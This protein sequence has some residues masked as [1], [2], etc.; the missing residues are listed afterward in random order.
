MRSIHKGI[1]FGIVSAILMMS[2]SIAAPIVASSAD[3]NIVDEERVLY[4]LI[5]R[6]EVASDASDFEKQ[7]AVDAFIARSKLPNK[8]SLRE[9]RNEAKRLQQSK[10]ASKQLKV[11]GAATTAL[12]NKTVKVMAVLID[13]PDLPHDDNGLSSSDTEMFY[14]SYPAEHYQNLLFSTNGYAGPSGQTLMT[15]YQYYQAESGQ[16]LFFTGTVQGW[17]RAANNAAYYGGNSGG[18]ADDVNAA[19]L[20][21]EAVAAAAAQM[22]EVELAS[23]DI[24]D[25]YDFNQNGI[26]DEPD[27]EIDHVMIFHSSIGEEVGGGMLGGDAIWSHRASI[28]PFD[29]PGTDMMLST[30]TIQP[31]DAALGVCVHEFGHD[32]G[33]K[34]EY[35]I[36]GGGQ[37]SPVGNWSVMASGSWA[38]AIRGTEPVGFSPYARAYLQ[39]RYQ[40]NW[41]SEQK[42]LLSSLDGS[43]LEVALVEAVNHEGV[44]QISLDIPPEELDFT[45]PY[46]G[47]Y[48]FYSDQGDLL[49]HAMSLD[50][51]LPVATSLVL[52][53]QAHWNI[54]LDY[55]Y[56]QVM[57]DGVALAGNYTKA[58]ND[59]NSAK[60][61][62]TGSSSELPA[63]QGDNSWVELEYDLSAY[64]GRNVRLSIRYTTDAYVG[65]Y[66]IVIDDISIMQAG[67]PWLFIGAETTG[68]AAFA[69]F[70]R[71]SDKRPGKD[72]RYLV[73]LRSHKGVDQGLSDERYDPGVV[74]WLENN[75]YSTNEVSDHA[76][77]SLIGVVDADQNLIGYLDSEFQMRDAAFS[78]FNQSAYTRNGS[79]DRHLSGHKL[80]A[81]TNDYSAPLQPE[82]GMQL[83]ELGLSMEVMAQ[84]EDSS[85]AT[86]QF[87]YTGSAV[88]STELTAVIEYVQQGAQVSF[89]AN[90]NGGDGNY[91]YAW[92]FGVDDAVSA[93]TKPSYTYSEEGS[94]LVT[95]TITDGNGV[96]FTNSSTVTISAALD[97]SF[98]STVNGLVVTFVNLSTGGNGELSY[99]WEFGDG[100]IS[101]QVSPSHSYGSTGDYSVVLTVTDSDGQQQSETN[102]VSVKSTATTDTT[103]TQK[104]GSGG[105]LGMLSLL[106][107]LFFASFRRT[108]SVCV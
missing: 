42:L 17:Y 39:E 59:T 108:K 49:S 1:L 80:F 22:N 34:D 20:V 35:D 13:F 8:I 104:S 78:L 71:V 92:D 14:S 27:G 5:K 83:P 32:L 62:I 93:L 65:D 72:R 10:Q 11:S 68:E 25:P 73:Q 52:T 107:L 75:N 23:Y 54:E 106:C 95:L 29:I 99:L 50:V 3:A 70:L 74:L 21:K 77:Y 56:A 61:I 87:T 41:V 6:G 58:S 60:N 101:S 55:D 97:A 86:V 37:G 69:G 103:S 26:I 57:V 98:T 43:G 24:E 12:I 36:S 28:F 30:Y 7:L 53:M 67:E 47:D 102:I 33:L 89:S 16:T 51:E 94:Y 91:E 44:N 46:S 40:G 76:G 90:V 63:A 96:V 105:G 88:P 18:A 2:N 31:I 81:D 15:G 84:A 45:A 38:G 100:V 82:S 66:G 79:T 85:T 64:A 4:W 19:E 9:A 48:Q